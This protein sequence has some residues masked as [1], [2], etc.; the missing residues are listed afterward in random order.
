M[1]EKI[2]KM[3][4]AAQIWKENTSDCWKYRSLP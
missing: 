3:Q 1:N 2:V 4:I